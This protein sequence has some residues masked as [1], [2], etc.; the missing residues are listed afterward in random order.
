MAERSERMRAER[1]PT[2]DSRIIL[3]RPHISSPITEFGLSRIK[4]GLE[5]S[6]KA[7]SLGRLLGAVRIAL[8][9]YRCAERPEGEAQALID[10]QV[11]SVSF[12]STKLENLNI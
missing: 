9:S 1:S 6:Q 11:Y 2:S 10:L 5:L 4:A 12:F 8:H 3:S 7:R